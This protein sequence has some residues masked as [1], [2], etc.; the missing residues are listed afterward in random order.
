M[1]KEITWNDIVDLLSS[2]RSQVILIMPAIHEEW[3]A[4]LK[5]NPNIHSIDLFACIDNSEL[6][7]RNGYGSLKGIEELMNLNANIK[8]C[9]GL[10]INFIS[11]DDVAYFIFLESRIIAGNPEGLNAIVVSSEQALQFKNQFFPPP[12]ITSTL[13]VQPL[14]EDR[15]KQ[16]KEA[17]TNNPPEEPDLKRRINTYS[18]L[19]QYMEIHFEGANIQSATVTIPTKALPFKD[20]ELKKRMKTRYNLFTKEQT[21][22]W[23]SLL[24]I[25][26][27]VEELRKEYLTPC[28]LKKN[29][30]IIK[31]ESRNVF[32]LK[33]EKLKKESEENI[34]IIIGDVQ[35]EIQKSKL[36]LK[37]E[38]TTFI[39]EN[40]PKE[41][42]AISYD[43]ELK[44]S[45][46][47]E[48]VQN[49][50]ASA[51]IPSALDLIDKIK[52]EKQD[53]EFTVDDLSDKEFLNWFK[54][55]KLI[56]KSDEN[57]LAKFTNAFQKKL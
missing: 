53:A 24:D 33:F 45:M 18:T 31:K 23:Q 56:N 29:R 38:L 41:I 51:K 10:R 6:V 57:E 27:K 1:I 40:E 12:E 48:Y 2:A 39:K 34:K 20:E 28:K 13:P 16:V 49:A 52:L 36:V 26:Q 35:Q 37:N 4:A 47:G 19:F 15:F 9:P 54:E 3:I 17:I 43:I 32:I 7:I 8:E 22:K 5:I 25:K 11:I 50:I 55:K 42:K 44:N 21:D 14:V 30:S 46:I